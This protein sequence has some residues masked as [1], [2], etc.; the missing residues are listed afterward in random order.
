MQLQYLSLLTT[1]INKSTA[2]VLWRTPFGFLQ[3]F[4]KIL[5]FK[6]S[7]WVAVFYFSTRLQQMTIINKTDR[8]GNSMVYKKYWIKTSQIAKYHAKIDILA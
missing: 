8:N 6:I 3:Y 4:A 7:F 2:I 1:I 5:C